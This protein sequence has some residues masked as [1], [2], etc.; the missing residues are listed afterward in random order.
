ME[1]AAEVRSRQQMVRRMWRFSEVRKRA[2]R[3]RTALHDEGLTEEHITVHDDMLDRIRLEARWRVANRFRYFRRHRIP[4]G[5]EPSSDE[6]DRHAKEEWIWVYYCYPP[7][8]INFATTASEESEERVS[9]DTYEA[10]N[11]ESSSEESDVSNVTYVPGGDSSPPSAA[12]S[13]TPEDNLLT[14]PRSEADVE[15]LQLSTDTDIDMTS[16]DE[17]VIIITSDSDVVMVE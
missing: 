6:D 12:V 10:R 8:E 7:E 17:D 4:Y 13:P 5:P 16:S 11:Q 3:R 1:K 15:F 9:T 14:P 2:E